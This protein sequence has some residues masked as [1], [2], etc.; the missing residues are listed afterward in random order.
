MAAEQ[1]P[2]SVDGLEARPTRGGQAPSAGEGLALFVVGAL[3]VGAVGVLACLHDAV[4]WRALAALA[5]AQDV[6]RQGDSI[7]LGYIGFVEPPLPT[8]LMV[9]IAWLAPGLA[10]SGMAVAVF[11][12]VVAGLTLRSLN[13]LCADVGLGRLTRWLLCLVA[14]VNPV[15]LGLAATGSPDALYI[16]L[17]LGGAWALLR[18]QRDNV[19]R[20]LISCSFFFSFAVL[21]RY[22]AV[23]PTAAAVLVVALITV[24]RGREWAR[25]EGTLLTFV[26]PVAY[27]SGLWVL[28][29]WLIMGEPWHFL[30]A[31]WRLGAMG[32]VSISSLSSALTACAVFV[33][34]LAGVWWSAWGGACGR[35]RLALGAA[36]VLLSPVAGVVLAPELFA[37]WLSR[38]VQT[39]LPLLAMPDL[40]P[41]LLAAG[42]LLTACMVGDVG[43]LFRRKGYT[44]EVCL[45]GG[46]ALFALGLLLVMGPEERVYADPRPVFAGQPLGADD[47]AGAK[48]A[49]ERLRESL[50][51]ESRGT[52]VIGG[53]PGYAV[54]LY[55]DRTKAKVLLVDPE[56][57]EQPIREGPAAGLLLRA[58]GGGPS[59]PQVRKR[60][61]EALG[62]PVDAE[63][64]WRSD[65]WAYYPP[66][67]R[68]TPAPTP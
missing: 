60:W 2:P 21:T 22:E 28:A 5:H 58:N 44:K 19:L 24:Y 33:P 45:A 26:L 43:P 11:G 25:L 54:A 1:A 29:N 35:P 40:F 10:G 3:I 37:G 7:N 18:W 47:A 38:T 31:S 67:V 6:L 52:L 48:L 8:L 66:R 4:S 64:A 50:P 68:S 16:L 27:V 9:P 42:W 34:L 62:V 36:V 55:A 23:V 53:W 41:P 65:G 30:Q 57:P 39:E 63:P 51:A 59:I 46:A 61:E 56:P 20:D 49:A 32:E 15:Y 17:L 12:A 14:F 13:A